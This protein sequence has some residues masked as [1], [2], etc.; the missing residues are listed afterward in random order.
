MLRSIKT[1]KNNLIIPSSSLSQ[2]RKLA[3]KT[4]ISL[5]ISNGV[6]GYYNRNYVPQQ[7]LKQI[8][9]GTGQLLKSLETQAISIIKKY[10]KEF[11]AWSDRQII[12]YSRQLKTHF[13]RVLQPAK[14]HTLEEQGLEFL[15]QA[16]GLVREAAFRELGYRHYKEQL[17]AGLALY[18][19]CL[20]E[21]QT[22]EGKTLALTAPAYLAS[23]VGQGLH[24][25][26][27]NEYLAERDC[28][29]MGGIYARLGVSSAVITAKEQFK[30]FSKSNLAQLQP[31]SR[32]EAYQCDITY[33]TASAFG[34]DYLRD[35][36]VFRREDL[37]QRPNLTF[38]I[39]DEADNILLD[40][41]RTPLIISGRTEADQ[42]FYYRAIELVQRLTPGQDY[43]VDRT[44]HFASFTEQGIEKLEKWLKVA[45]PNKNLASQEGLYSGER[46][47]LF[48][49][50]NCLKAL[51]LYQ[52]DED[53]LVA[54]ASNSNKS[55][56]ASNTNDTY[57]KDNEKYNKA[58]Q[59]T[60][61][62]QENRAIREIVLI[63]QV[64]GRPMP[65]RRLGGGLHEALEA[66]E[67]LMIK[68]PTTTVA[69]IA[70]Q[71]YF[72]R[73][74][75]LAGLSGTLQTD[76]DIFYRLYGLE[77]VVIGPHHPLQRIEVPALIYRTGAVAINSLIE[78]TLKVRE[79]GAPILIG[80]PSVA[81]SEEVSALLKASKV[82]HQLL[83]ARQT[84][85]EAQMIARAGY[86]G[87]ITVATNIAGRGTDI[88]LGGKYEDH[89][90]DLAKQHGL[91]KEADT[92]TEAWRQLE[93]EAQ[94]R[95]QRAKAIVYRAGGLHVLGLGLQTSRRLDRQLAGRAGRQGD[96]GYSSFFYSLE[97]DLVVRYAGDSSSYRRLLSDWSAAQYRAEIP[98]DENLVSHSQAHQSQA[99]QSL[100][101]LKLVEECQRK[102][103][104]LQLDILVQ[105]IEFDSV[106]NRQR[107]LFYRDR[108]LMLLACAQELKTK[109]LE[110]VCATKK[111]F[112]QSQIK[113]LTQ[114]Y[115]RAEIRLGETELA[116]RLRRLVLTIL[117]RA[118]V[119]YLTPLEE[120]RQG[121]GLRSYGG[122]KPL[123]SYQLEARTLWE[124]FQ[125]NTKREI[126][127]AFQL[128]IQH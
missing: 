113:H 103:E 51:T 57:P 18:K 71:A 112:G 60:S 56:T 17:M 68:T 10:E 37:V 14:A 52:R 96:P 97:D 43:E 3:T 47:E 82:P 31:C 93:K 94:R 44:K 34:F 39:L 126:A 46:A 11:A 109:I 73:Y 72:K 110:L 16:F 128:F 75:R 87:R 23:L 119:Q 76:K 79:S 19:G 99:L 35:H 98:S 45:Y 29:T 49:L 95:H 1:G 58:T 81:V 122:Q 85:K 117:D 20:V 59:Q 114:A 6:V 2:K 61:R 9:E 28:L 120:L 80:T 106:L 64:T 102:A 65:G 15:P 111:D 38:A 40:E 50:L 62:G 88:L 32:R 55:E 26:T 101:A 54:P 105:G 53:Y 36:L 7:I 127:E 86:P 116:D 124:V 48:Y 69:T 91:V 83:N 77:T 89:L 118:W 8:L 25:V 115:R 121:I 104:G 27:A 92:G 84:A 21:M 125:D 42:N 74:E 4:V 108:Q 100:L 5:T 107:E 70:L 90:A 12:D 24:V 41:A 78:T 67:G 123:Q 30:F 66:K 22:G 33:G 13:N 63:D